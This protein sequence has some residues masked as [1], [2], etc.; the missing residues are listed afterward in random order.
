MS[1]PKVTQ[2]A[3]TYDAVDISGSNLFGEEQPKQPETTVSDKTGKDG[4]NVQ[5]E[6][7]KTSEKPTEPEKPKEPEEPTVTIGDKTY[8]QSEI[9]AALD[10]VK[11]KKDWQKSNTEQ[12]QQTAAQRKAVEPLIQLIN[13]MRENGETFKEIKDILIDTLGEDKKSLVEK[14]LEFDEKNYPNPFKDELDKNNKEL[15]ILRGEK[16]FNEGL[17]EFAKKQELSDVKKRD[18]KE[19]W[20]K[21]YDETGELLEFEDAYKLMSY[22]DLKKKVDQRKSPNPPPIP[23]KENSAKDIKDGVP[24]SYEDIKVSGVFD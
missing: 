24:K 10:D 9:E 7:S 18:L 16:L 15:E 5:P 1:E 6:E 8:T 3:E 12:A 22:D 11:N 23:T 13:S 20:H 4:E 21:K 2:T 17:D 14:A 19:F